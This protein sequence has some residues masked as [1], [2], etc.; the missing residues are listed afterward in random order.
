[1]PLSLQ[2]I[3]IEITIM[4]IVYNQTRYTSLEEFQGSF[5]YADQE[6]LQVGKGSFSHAMSLVILDGVVI[7]RHD[8]NRKTLYEGVIDADLFIF[9]ASSLSSPIVLNG[10]VI[11]SQRL[12]FLCPNEGFISVCPV[13]F[14][15]YSVMVSR[16]ELLDL[17]GF[18]KLNH[19]I[20]N[21]NSI[22]SGKY[23]L[24]ELNAFISNIRNISMLTLENNHNFSSVY[25]HDLKQAV[26][27]EIFSLFNAQDEDI[28]ITTYDR[29]LAV[30]RR[31]KEYLDSVNV[32]TVSVGEL[33]KQC[34]CSRRTLEYSFRKVLTFSPNE[35]L[36]MKRLQLIRAEFLM[37]DSGEI[38]SILHK[39]GVVNQGRF[40]SDY[41]LFFGEYPKDTLKT[42]LIRR[43]HNKS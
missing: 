18:E 22:R 31:A 10:N 11:D 7:S 24:N 35:Y 32:S 17:L 37:E 23:E 36:K 29:R 38:H 21:A 26:L 39:Y 4:D 2:G 5:E 13:F 1:M 34:F 6:V 40:S 9:Q 30:V 25:A 14:S 3:A 8:V 16:G 43:A 42:N 28:S 27:Q 33:A 15:G 19:I 41:R 12:F 20:K